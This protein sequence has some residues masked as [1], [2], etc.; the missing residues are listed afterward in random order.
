MAPEM[1]LGDPSQ[2]SAQTDVYLLGAIFFEIF[3]GRPPH[4]G[5][6]LEAMIANILL[7]RTKFP[8]S[9]PSEAAR[10]CRRA[11]SRDPA[12]RYASVEEFRLAIEEYVRHRGSR[13]LAHDAKQSL[14]LLL[15]AIEHAPKGEERTLAVFNRLGEC[16]FGYRAA[17]NAWPENEAARKGLDRA[18]LAVVDHE[19]TEGDPNAAQALLREVAEVPPDVVARVDDAIKKRAAEDERLRRLE[20]DFDPTI[21]T[22][23][24]SFLGG[25]F[26]FLW[27][28]TPLVSWYLHDHIGVHTTYAAVIGFSVAFLGL[29]LGTYWWARETLTKTALNRRLARTL[30]LHLC[31]QI[32]LAGGAWLAAVP[33]DQL[34]VL[35]IFSWTL[36]LTMVAVWTEKWFGVAAAVSAVSFLAAS[37]Y[38]RATFPIMS[39]DNFVLTVLLLRVWLRKQDVELLNQRRLEMRRRARAWL[40]EAVSGDA[41]PRDED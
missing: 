13:K 10:I 16:R 35:V 6:N 41:S 23:T 28:V 9:F 29:G 38:P 14:T 26:G 11:M 24:R 25:M 15:D 37:K 2:L 18:L 19:L 39:F 12:G 22:R 17:L 31:A 40:T 36:T 7:S 20:G 34:L 32:L 30:A 3:A 21:G 1:L 4:E 33:A 27:T 8:Q 5:E